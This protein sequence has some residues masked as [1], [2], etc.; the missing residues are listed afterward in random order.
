MPISRERA[1]EIVERNVGGREPLT[2]KQGLSPVSPDDRPLPPRVPGGQDWS[3]AGQMERREF[4]AARGVAIAALSGEAQLPDPESLRGNIE[5]FIGMAAV[6]VGLIGPLRISGL[7]ARGD[8]YV[9]LATSEG[10]LVASYDRGA[11]LISNSGGAVCLLTQEQVQRAPGFAFETLADAAHFAVWAVD[12]IETFRAVTASQTRH[13]QLIDMMT[14]VE[15][16]HVYLIFAFHPG[17]AAGQNMVTFISAAICRDILERTPI[18]PSFWFL[19]SNL[20]GDKK[21]TAMSF[22]NTRGRNV[23]AEAL[24]PRR[25]VERALR[26]TPERMEDYW[27]MSFVAGV[28]TGSIG[29]SG[30]I[31]N[32]LAALFL[33]C[34]QDVACVSEASVGTTR[35]EVRD[36]DLY[37]ALTLPN[38]IVGT[39]GGGTTLPTAR[40]CLQILDCVGTGKAG[41]L[42][43]ICAA[44]ALA[45][46]ISIV[47]ALC[48]HEFADAHRRLGRKHTP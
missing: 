17:D 25:L 6:P 38:L 23:T 41:R 21:A 27:R 35:M 7:H 1:R 44:T 40:E 18:Q 16:N 30:H 29:V 19:E 37:C 31:A 28:Q 43:E 34:G 47:G 13:G 45:G 39:V 26:T 20:S 8:F 22:L 36:G 2:I 48:A 12:Q 24:L 42:A 9:P 10:A 4:L 3:A 32:G 46:E 11:R 5:H 14:H 15:G 33:A